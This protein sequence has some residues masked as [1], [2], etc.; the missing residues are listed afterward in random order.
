[1]TDGGEQDTLPFTSSQARIRS[2]IGRIGVSDD[3]SSS[4][5]MLRRDKLSTITTSWSRA[6]RCNAVGQPQNPSPPRI[7]IF[8][9]LPSSNA[10]P[11]VRDECRGGPHRVEPSTKFYSPHALIVP[12]GSREDVA[13]GPSDRRLF[14]ENFSIVESWWRL[15]AHMTALPS[16]TL[17]DRSSIGQH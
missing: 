11:H 9:N 5:S 7:R 2:P 6:E 17:T 10:L 13:K 4:L 15:L 12:T 8:N 14:L 1:M 16:S 3:A